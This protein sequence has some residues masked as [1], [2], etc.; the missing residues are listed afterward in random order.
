MTYTYDA[1]ERLLTQVLSGA[2]TSYSYDD[3]NQMTADGVTTVTYDGTGNRGGYTT[4]TGNRL[5][6]DGGQCTGVVE[7]VAETGS[8]YQGWGVSGWKASPT[9]VGVGVC[10]GTSRLSKSSEKVAGWR[11]MTR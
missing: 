3:S 8:R 7:G 5:E 4:G 11:G 6:D 9:E 10:V 2:T 1:G